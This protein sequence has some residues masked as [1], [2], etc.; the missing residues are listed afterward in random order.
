M[1]GIL[2]GKDLVE[3]REHRG[4]GGSDSPSGV[5]LYARFFGDFEVFFGG[6]AIDLGRNG[7]AVAVL[8]NLCWLASRVRYRK[9]L[10]WAG[11]GRSQTLR[12]PGGR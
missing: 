4:D 7:K 10:S 1:Q 2:V 6:G 5:H 11:C 3:R 8:K 9:I 12:E